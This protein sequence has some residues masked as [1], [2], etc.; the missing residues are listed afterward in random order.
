MKIDMY[1]NSYRILSE[2]IYTHTHKR[3]DTY[4]SNNFCNFCEKSIFFFFFFFGDKN[5]YINF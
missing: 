1:C 2:L 4:T 5:Y 3:N